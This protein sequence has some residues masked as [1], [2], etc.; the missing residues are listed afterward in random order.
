[1]SDAVEIPGGM[2]G[3]RGPLFRLIRD[4]RVAFLLVGGFNTG[5][6]FL[7]FVAFD[8]TVGRLVDGLAGRVVGSLATLGCAHVVAVLVAFVMYRTFVFRVRGHVW[9]DLLRFQAVYLLSTGINAVVL[10]I[11]VHLGFNRILVQLAFLA[12]SVCISYFGHKHFSFRRSAKD[13]ARHE[14]LP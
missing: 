4:Q 13:D 5:I 2:Q 6:G 8:L 1:M 7:L 10:P 14:A 9:R 11:F 12:V 3:E